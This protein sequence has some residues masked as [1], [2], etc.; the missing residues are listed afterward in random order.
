VAITMEP[1]CCFAKGKQV[2]QVRFF[3]HGLC[4]MVV[5]DNLLC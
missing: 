3:K 2:S 4:K 5:E 1:I